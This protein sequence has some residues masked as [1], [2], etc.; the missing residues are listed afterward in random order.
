LPIL[1]VSEPAAG[2]PHSTRAGSNPRG[3]RCPQKILIAG[4]DL[5]R[6]SHRHQPPS[7]LLGAVRMPTKGLSNRDGWAY[8]LLPNWSNSCLRGSLVDRAGGHSRGYRGKEDSA[9]RGGAAATPLGRAPCAGHGQYGQVLE[10]TGNNRGGSPATRAGDRMSR[11]ASHSVRT[12]TTDR[13][14][15]PRAPASPGAG[16]GAWR[17]RCR[18][19]PL[20][21]RE[22]SEYRE[23]CPRE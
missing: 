10:S 16:K 6:P 17:H 18:A 1:R 22:V 4:D 3:G 8:D 13:R 15:L 19:P 23:F 20:P 21:A 12:G 2:N 11:G 7:G 9:D 14:H 5:R